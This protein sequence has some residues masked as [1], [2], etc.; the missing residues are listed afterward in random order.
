M[1]LRISPIDIFGIDL[2]WQYNDFQLSTTISFK[3]RPTTAHCYFNS[4]LSSKFHCITMLK[5]PVKADI[6]QTFLELE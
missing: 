2:S 4:F 3:E 1:K 6:I 5:M